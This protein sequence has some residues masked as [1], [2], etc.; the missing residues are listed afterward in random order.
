MSLSGPRLFLS[1]Y[2]SVSLSVRMHTHEQTYTHTHL[3]RTQ[4]SRHQSITI[5]NGREPST[6]TNPL[7][8]QSMIAADPQK[9]KQFAHGRA[10][11]FTQTLFI[12]P[13]STGSQTLGTSE[14]QDSLLN[15]DHWPHPRLRVSDSKVWDGA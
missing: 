14:H 4:L 1:F 13:H 2:P 8:R 15:A 9:H 11:S 7:T 6:H 5:N 3:P 10:P 12:P